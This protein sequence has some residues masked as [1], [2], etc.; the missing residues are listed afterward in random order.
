[1]LHLLSN[2]YNRQEAV[3]Y[4]HKWAFGRN[5]A[6]YDFKGIGGDCTNFTS[7]CLYAGAKV[8]NYTPTFG[9]YY[10]NV[11]RR[12]PAWTSVR[13]FHQ[14]LINNKGVGPYGSEAPMEKVQIGDFS[15]LRLDGNDFEH[16]QIIVSMGE[17]PTLDNI[18][19]AAHSIDSDNRPLSTYNIRDIRFIH[20]EGVR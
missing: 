7:Q 10:I 8:M 9:W 19:V 20:I 2:S 11:N 14:F 13:Y 5:P 18:L 16:T 1:M 17:P 3:N 15:Q 6:F 12:A 4:A